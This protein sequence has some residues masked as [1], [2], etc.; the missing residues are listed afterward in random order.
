MSPEKQTYPQGDTDFGKKFIET[1]KCWEQCEERLISETL[2]IS[3]AK[4]TLSRKCEDFPH[5]GV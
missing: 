4:N 1:C 5:D 2:S 3:H